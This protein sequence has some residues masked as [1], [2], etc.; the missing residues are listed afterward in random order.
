MVDMSQNQLARCPYCQQGTLL[1]GNFCAF[2][3]AQL[4]Q[5]PQ[6][7]PQAAPQPYQPYSQPP[8]RAQPPQKAREGPVNIV[9]SSCGTSNEP[10]FDTCKTCKRSLHETRR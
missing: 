4:R 2:C 5:M 10:W 1:A 3:G 6:A 8:Q 9:C 7:Q